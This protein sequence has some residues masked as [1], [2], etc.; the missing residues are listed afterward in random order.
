MTMREALTRSGHPMM[1]GILAQRQAREE[2]E[3]K[4][5]N[6]RHARD[7]RDKAIMQVHRLSYSRK[8]K[9]GGGTLVP[10]KKENRERLASAV[11]KAAVYAVLSRPDHGYPA[12]PYRRDP[13]YPN[14]AR[15][16]S[17]R[18]GLDMNHSVAERNRLVFWLQVLKSRE[19]PEETIHNVE[20]HIVHLAR[21][22]DAGRTNPHIRKK[23]GS[24]EYTL[25]PAPK[26]IAVE[27]RR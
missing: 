13:E 16:G 11:Q 9:T 26:A 1:V 3:R 18:K 24:K 6:M 27:Y 5:A 12:P 7:M 15:M 17:P 19:T 23:P 2:Q 14:G 20:S 8:S 4:R 21:R 22:V 25:R 10:R